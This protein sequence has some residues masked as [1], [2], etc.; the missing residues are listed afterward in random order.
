MRNK[1]ISVIILILVI[2]TLCYIF[3]KPAFNYLSGYLS[4]SEHVKAN[5]LIVEGWLDRDALEMAG[6]EYR[7]NSYDHIFAIGMNSITPYFKVYSNGYLIFYPGERF[8]GLNEPGPH[9]IEIDAF[10][11]LGGEN[12]AHF[13]LFINDSLKADF[14]TNTHKRTYGTQWYGSL[15]NIDSII[16][17]FDNDS[18][19][20]F[21][22]RNLYVKEVKIDH[23]LVIPYLNNSDYD[24][25]NLD[26]QQRLIN[27]IKSNA[28][29]AR[30]HLIGMGIDPSKIT[31]ISAERVRINRTLNTAIAFRDWLDS[32]NTDIKGI[33]IISKGTHARRT[34]MTYN[35]ILKEKYDIGI[36]SL[37]ENK[38][39][40][41]GVRSIV[42]TFRETL[43]IIY[44]WI[45]LSFY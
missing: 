29:F 17:Q 18:W 8:A 27:N 13:N 30:R 14:L 21:G 22:D 31:A 34:W 35:K 42:K 39:F 38:K 5:I 28:E 7:T 12:R 24:I 32:K 15:N 43:G 45:I 4:K 40:Y 3:I 10:S 1:I 9:L 2:V 44:Y 36:I 11:E 6:E 41:S 23:D 20:K 33:N 25:I 16:V 37:P 26:G 19:G